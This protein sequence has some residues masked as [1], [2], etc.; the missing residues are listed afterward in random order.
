MV[1]IS[2]GCAGHRGPP[3]PYWER[4]DAME[5]VET[6]LD[7][8]AATLKRWRRRAPPETRFIVP[9]APDVV[10]RRFEGPEAE[11]AWGRTLEVAALLGADT[12]L[13][14]TPPSLRPTLETRKAIISFFASHPVE[15]HV[16]WR[17][18]G[19]WE[20]QP[21][22]WEEV[23][24][25]GNLVPIV[26]PLGPD[27]SEELPAGPFF[28]WT[29]QGGMGMSSRLGDHELDTLLELLA[30]RRSGYIM[31]AAP[32]MMGAADR[33]RNLLVLEGI[34][35]EASPV[36]PEEAELQSNG[37]TEGSG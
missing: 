33:L 37:A 11:A 18:P 22:H 31:F 3:E 29:I 19:L 5:L 15:H 13:L 30:S 36:Q 2:V 34:T 21:D 23:C 16:A 14:S 1:T 27:D 8:K 28:Y 24:R 7:W 35:Q 26:D 10:R 25:S 4:L 20:S 6:S 32:R 17:A 12:L 9:V